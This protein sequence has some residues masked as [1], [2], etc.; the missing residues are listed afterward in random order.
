[1]TTLTAFVDRLLGGPPPPP[2]RRRSTARD[3]AGCTWAWEPEARCWPV[4]NTTAWSSG[5]PGRERRPGS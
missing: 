5:H 2:P 3:G 1:M 4:P